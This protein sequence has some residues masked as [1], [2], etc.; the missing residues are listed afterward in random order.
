M[1]IGAIEAGGTKFVAGLLKSDKAVNASG[2]I[3]P[4]VLKLASFPT[5]SPKE[6]VSI[7]CQWF[8]AKLPSNGSLE[9]LGLASFGPLAGRIGQAGWGR[10]GPTP[11]PGWSGFD[12]A[13]ALEKELGVKAAVDTDVNAAALAEGLWGAGKGLS[14]YVYVTVGTGIGAGIVSGGKLVHGAGHP[15][16]GHVPVPREQGD[17][18]PG[19]CPFHADCLEGMAS[20]PAVAGRWGSAPEKLPP[21]HPAWA[22]EAKYLASGFLPFVHILASERIILGGGL[23]S[24]PWLMPMI[25]KSLSEKL[26]SYTPRL[27][28]SHA[29]DSFISSPGLGSKAGI[30]GAAALAL[31]YSL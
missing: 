5:T 29:M 22:L 31:A 30:L 18:Y 6:T 7:V 13:G 12:L 19:C 3:A 16:A 2:P 25:K 11:K 4:E 28:T 21:D 15:E 9:L 14:D 27:D 10:L 1:I 8:R 17:K 20:G 23:G 24:L 26:A